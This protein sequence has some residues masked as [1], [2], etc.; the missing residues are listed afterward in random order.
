[1]ASLHHRVR[2]IRN[3]LFQ[4]IEESKFEPIDFEMSEAYDEDGQNIGHVRFTFRANPG[5]SF[6][7][8]LEPTNSEDRPG[9]ISYC[10]AERTWK[11]MTGCDDVSYIKMH[12]DDWLECLK[13]EL[14]TPDLW[15]EFLRNRPP[16]SFQE[17]ERAPNDPLPAD[18]INQIGER[19]KI[20]ESR[21]AEQ[22]QLEE[23]QMEFIRI[24]FAYLSEKAETEG[25]TQKDWKLLFL[26]TMMSIV[27][28]LAFDPAK[29]SALWQLASDVM[30][31][32]AGF[33]PPIG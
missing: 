22:F 1:M 29:A 26:A 24:E 31:N 18:Q 20:L 28:T 8:N 30:S 27:T 25:I 10:P 15:A 2:A 17:G 33:L 6:S 9:E 11:V 16:T 7:Y 3:D 21:I 14:E 12:L 5:F 4:S 19:L 32:I 23:P 13:Q